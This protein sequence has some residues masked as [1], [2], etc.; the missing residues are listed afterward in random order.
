MQT[1]TAATKEE[2][3]KHQRIVKKAVNKAKEVWIR[4]VVME[5]NGTRKDRKLNG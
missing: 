4:T 1:P 2:F 3:R 5:V